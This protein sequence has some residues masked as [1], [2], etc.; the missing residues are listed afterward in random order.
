MK[1]GPLVRVIL[2]IE[3]QRLIEFDKFELSRG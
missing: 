3:V 1:Q 2:R